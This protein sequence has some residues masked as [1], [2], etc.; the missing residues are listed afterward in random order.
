MKFIAH[1]A[2]RDRDEG[3]NAVKC[4]GR[5]VAITLVIVGLL[6]LRA[7]AAVV[8][9]GGGGTTDNW[10]DGGAGGN[11]GGAAAPVAGDDVVFDHADSG[12]TNIADYAVGLKTLTYQLRPGAETSFTQNTQIGAGLTLSTTG[13]FTVGPEDGPGLT[14]TIG[15]NISGGAGSVFQVGATG[16]NT[17]DLIIA[18]NPDSNDGGSGVNGVLTVNLDMSGLETFVANLDDLLVYST[19]RPTGG[20]VTLAQ[21]N[22][23]TANDITVGHHTGNTSKSAT[24]ELGQTNT[25]NANTI[26]FGHRKTNATVRFDAGLAA[27]GLTLRGKIGGDSRVA[28]LRI[29]YND[30]GTSA[31]PTGTLDL[32]DGSLDARVNSMIVGLKSYGSS[33]DGFGVVRMAAGTLDVTALV[34]GR[35]A[36]NTNTGNVARGTLELQGGTVAAGSIELGD[37]DGPGPATGIIEQTGGSI[38]VAGSLSDGGGS[39][40]ILLDNGTMTVGGGLSVDRLYVGTAGGNTT[41]TLN[42]T[43]GTVAIGSGPAVDDFLVGR[44]AGNNSGTTTTGIVDLSGASSAAFDVDLFHVGVKGDN[45]NGVARGQVTLAPDNTIVAN[46]IKVGRS[47]N[48]GGSGNELHFGSGISNVT[49]PTLIVGQCKATGLV[50]VATG[51]TVNLGS[52]GNRTEITVGLKD[53]YTGGSNAS[54]IDFSAGSANIFA[55]NI[56]L[57]QESNSSGSG[58]PSG[59]LILGDGSLDVTG[60]VWEGSTTTGH[61]TSTLSVLGDQ[62]FTVGGTI[63]VDH[64][65]V[66]YKDSST[67]PNVVGTADFSGNPAVTMILGD[68]HVGY[69]VGGGSTKAK[70]TL[71]LGT[72]NDIT[73]DMIVVGES[74]SAYQTGAGDTSSIALGDTNVV[75]SNQI[76]IGSDRSNGTVTLAAG[77]TLDLASR[78]GGRAD[79]ELGL[80]DVGTNA[81]ATGILDLSLGDRFDALLDVF[82]IGDKGNTSNGKGQGIVTLAQTNNIDA[83]SI[84]VGR[85]GNTGATGGAD[86][87]QLHLG[88]G[89]NT[90]LTPTLLVGDRKTTGLIDFATPGGTLDLGTATARTEITLGRK[91]VGTAN[92]A[93][94][95]MDLRDGTANIFASNIMLG[96]ETNTSG[97]GTPSGTIW[98]GDGSLDVSGNIH[99]NHASGGAGNSTLNVVGDQTFTIG[100]T[101]A[102][103]HFRVGYNTGTATLTVKGGAVAIGNGAG[104]LDLGRRETASTAHTHGT[105]DLSG[106]SSVDIDVASVRLGT[107]PNVSQ[108]GD[109]QGILTLSQAGTNT[110]TADSIYLGNSSNRGNTSFTNQLHLGGADNTIATDLL[111]IGGH[112]SK[113]TV[114]IA[115]GGTLTLTGNSGAEADLEIGENYLG[116]GA[117]SVGVLDLS[118][119]TFN[120]TLDL[121]RIARHNTSSGN[122]EGTLTMD[123]G[124]VTAN[125]IEMAIDNNTSDPQNTRGTLNLNGGS[126]AVTG[127]ITDGDGTSTVNVDEGTLTVGGGMTVDTLRVGVDRPGGSTATVDVN[128]GAV[129]VGNGT[130]DLYVGRRH[131]AAGGSSSETFYGTLDVADADSFTANV[132]YFRV[133]YVT[134]GAGQLNPNGTVLLSPDNTITANELTV[135]HSDSVGLGALTNSIAFGADNT[136]R[137]NTVVI[138]GSKGIGLATIAAGGTLDLASKT[139]GRADLIVGQQVPWTGGGSDGTFDMTGGTLNALLDE[140]IIGDKFHTTSPGTAR[141]TLTMTGGALDANTILLAR[142]NGTVGNA[143]GTLNFSGGTISAGS[144]AKGAGTATF[145][146]T[147]GTLHVDDFG[148]DLL[149]DDPANPGTGTGTLAPGRSIGTTD[150]SG[151]YT[152]GAAATLEIE[153][154]GALHDLVTV[155]A[156]ATLDGILKVEFLGPAIPGHLYDVLVAAGGI[157][158]RGMDLQYDDPMYM[159]YSIVDRPDVGDRAQAVRLHY[160]PE[161]TTMALLLLGAAPLARRRR[162]QRPAR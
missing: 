85:S 44:N 119:G 124:T 51:G 39:S 123:A 7:E 47:G 108:E 12:N 13:N 31:A 53:V 48:N 59:N 125:R 33:G 8:T 41:G 30:T 18:Q 80:N 110:I 128:G 121:V 72:S 120:A 27:P 92:S 14:S 118:G 82:A 46:E 143:I 6:A 26:Y 100:G 9:W 151:S 159:Y 71:L 58:N 76:I 136:V 153:I 90:I 146:W 28:N 94:G 35:T 150:I 49:T 145:N 139:G 149:N 95:T 154:D 15:V 91:S 106:A 43:G 77:G 22:T 65:R 70:G 117:T 37:K 36:S 38:T 160:T 157:D 131:A 96:Q 144:I 132:R 73:A 155:S 50:D 137:A 55:S 34:L 81:K 20:T 42:V 61:G 101:I 19:T 23:V 21:N 69:K 63:A 97:S 79:L 102:V 62:T 99:E 67:G 127:S 3:E 109:T 84:I 104:I 98:L 148:L 52:A 147:G 83:N 103:D 111:R 89:V 2:R 138:G 45:S 4:T 25:L 56:N 112:K 57:G 122:A 141:G 162:K 130:E 135:A 60:N 142:R 66:G 140:L 75:R 161:P 126:I 24:L 10:S 86:Q 1:H 113:G 40:T 107:L 88:G 68:L 16:T 105:A 93:A 11:W 87:S 64:F 78:S 29:G 5:W 54:T 152:Q 115:A 133:G 156:L 17:A 158:D 134:G 74:D 129:N 32:T 114:D 116:T